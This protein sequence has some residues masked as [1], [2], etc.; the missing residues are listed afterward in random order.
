MGAGTSMQRMFGV[1]GGFAQRRRWTVLVVALLLTAVAVAMVPGIR[2]STSR[3]GLVSKDNPYQ[4]RLI[5]FFERFGSPDTPVVVVRG[6]DPPTRRRVVDRLVAELERRPA[7]RGRVLARI[8]PE[9]VAEVL[10]LQR[11]GAVSEFAR[12]TGTASLRPMV[13]GG[14]VGIVGATTDLVAGVL[15]GAVEVPEGAEASADA[16][17]TAA[18]TVVEAIDA[19]LAGRPGPELT[20]GA[21]PVGQAKFSGV[22]DAGYLATAD[23]TSHVIQTMPELA[24]DD[25]ARDLAPVVAE[26]R[27]ARDAAV[28]GASEG[29][30]AY[31]T[32]LPALAV[33]ELGYIEQGL[34]VS[35][36]V[37]A[38]G[39]VLFCLG[40]F[41][42]LR[43][44]IIA[45]VPLGVG[46]AWT[47]GAVYLI[48]GHLNLITSSFVAVL[49][50]LGIDFAV[51]LLSRINEAVRDGA[52][53]EEAARTGVAVTGP[54]IAVGALV[55]AIA[56]LTTG[57]TE[58][59]AYAELGVITA[60]GLLLIF[61]A[62]IFVVPPLYLWLGAGQKRAP[63]LP[64]LGKV[65][66][67]A[68]RSPRTLVVIGIAAG[69]AG[70]VALPRIEFNSNYFRFLPDDAE[71]AQGLSAL[72]GDPLMS[73]ITAN[74]VADDFAQAR[75]L[76]ERA[77]ALDV[78]GGVQSA[79]DFVPPMEE[80]TLQ[81]LAADLAAL[82][83]PT[84]VS[85]GRSEPDAL[86]RAVRD[87]ADT[88][89]EMRFAL[90]QA[91]R[92]ATGAIRLVAALR[93]LE[94]TVAS[95]GRDVA[96]R[97]RL[98]ELEDRVGAVV[99]RAH[100]ALAAVV[101][102]GGY[103]P[104]VVPEAFRSRFVS[105]DG[106]A[107]AI[108]VTPRGDIWD[109]EVGRAFAEAME[110][111]D[112]DAAG[113]GL[114]RYVHE[115]M[116]VEGFR[117][118]AGIAAILI[119]VTLLVDFRSFAAAVL[120]SLPTALGWAWMLAIMALVGLRFDPA[121]IVSLPLVLGI[122]VAYGVHMMHRVQAERRRATGPAPLDPVV[123]GTGGA[124][125]IAAVT[126]MVGFAALMV[127]DYGAMTSF[128][129]VMVLG[130]SGC[131]VAALVVLPAILVSMGRVK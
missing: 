83:G 76:A 53:P 124:V 10:L 21:L 62:T 117:R 109:P 103:G 38:A 122:G 119:F 70:A 93:A 65:A 41:R 14:L 112:E 130:I 18:A 24:G 87:L 101:E 50:G 66:S 27:S 51:H 88:A 11:P 28:E 86:A 17:V 45:L 68:R 55:T 116:I 84:P 106:T 91:G 113:L 64:G 80:G 105:R 44:S 98:R 77:R 54:G 125:V 3:Y 40:F 78:V 19:Y 131:L 15:E 108:Y 67:L 48:Y 72:E 63:E 34:Y 126:T 111:L 5:A 94:K 89:D 129:S 95:A 12:R 52:S 20:L 47:L 75:A 13:E 102:H 92:D 81:A 79:T 118:A 57:T 36:V 4:R 85:F 110:A 99:R 31:V 71:S 39:I 8:G 114:N 49:L 56:F 1:I 6:A 46:V 82:G 7:F 120:A 58:F 35:S 33:D 121:N 60:V 107:Y 30:V 59:T 128:G 42:S 25:A 123:R 43:K 29:I 73:P 97:D 37:A 61:L 32:G 127:V 2:I 26:V 22:D 100:G 9:Q 104:Y 96:V 23:G 74:L 115:K 16:S 90:K 69:I